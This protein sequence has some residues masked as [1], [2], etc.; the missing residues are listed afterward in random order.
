MFGGMGERLVVCGYGLRGIH[1]GVCRYWIKKSCVCM[2]VD[3]REYARILACMEYVVGH[4][5]LG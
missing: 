3:V 4:M 1:V 2:C 5:E